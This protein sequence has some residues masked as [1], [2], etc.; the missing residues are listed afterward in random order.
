M[1]LNYLMGNNCISLLQRNNQV[2][3]WNSLQKY[4]INPGLT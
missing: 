4:P 2:L 1:Y 3:I